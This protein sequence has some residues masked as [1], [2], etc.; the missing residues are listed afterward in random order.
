MLGKDL[1]LNRLFRNK[2]LF[3]VP[4]DHG[5]TIG[6]VQGLQNVEQTILQAVQGGV[7]AI[8][9]HKGLARLAAPALA[10]GS[11]DLILHLSAS[12]V[13]APD[14]QDKKLVSSVEYALR[15]GATAVSVHINLASRQEAAMLRD[16]GWVA[17]A[18]ALWGMPLLAMM[19]V[20]DGSTESEFDPGKIKHAARVAEEAGAD[21]IKINYTGS[22]ETFRE[23]VSSVRIPV[24]IAGG[25]KLA[26]TGQ[27]LELVAQAMEAGAR[28]IAIG[29]NIFQHPN[30][31]FLCTLIRQ[32]L[33]A[34]RPLEMLAA[35]TET[36]S[37]E[38][39]L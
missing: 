30:P 24:V 6:P 3:L 1:R 35:I 20:R 38:G 26:T 5:L 16:L 15:L 9:V 14:P 32:I 18:C 28:G 31:A 21:L 25:P 4:L 12:T 2:Q 29:R 19:Y 23:V 34:P 8:V 33:A 27:L 17:E 13:L 10:S 36:V 37:P 7:D 39:V 11:C 22:A